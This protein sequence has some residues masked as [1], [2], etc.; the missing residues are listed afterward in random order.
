MTTSDPAGVGFL[1]T[2]P[3]TEL[4]GSY[5]AFLPGPGGTML[6]A[7]KRDD[8][9]FCPDGAAR[10]G[11]LVAAALSPSYGLP[12]PDPGWTAGAWRADPRYDRP[13]GACA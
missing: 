13:H 7:R 5:S 10:V 2:G 1:P 4:A 9:H 12:P 11:A 3:A 8:I 6:R